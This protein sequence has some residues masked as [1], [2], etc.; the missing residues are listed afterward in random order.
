MRRNEW[1]K[2]ELNV[3]HVTQTRRLDDL[4]CEFSKPGIVPRL[5]LSSENAFA[6]RNHATI[7]AGMT[8]YITVKRP[9]LPLG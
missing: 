4:E 8:L 1:Q 9:T 3:H 5:W 2:R 6:R 7:R